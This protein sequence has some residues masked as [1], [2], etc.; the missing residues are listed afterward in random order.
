[1]AERYADLQIGARTQLGVDR[2][3][4]VEVV[5]PRHAQRGYQSGMS[6]APGS[7]GS[8][9]MID[10]SI[11]SAASASLAPRAELCSAILQHTVLRR[12]FR[13]ERKKAARGRAVAVLVAA[14]GERERSR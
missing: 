9:H 6:A 3:E 2:L 1:M 14:F 7:P 12:C 11:G 4:D 8:R 5:R 10:S 13:R